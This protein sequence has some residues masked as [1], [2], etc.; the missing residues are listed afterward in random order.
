MEKFLN[1]FQNDEYTREAVKG[2]FFAQLDK[3]AIEAVYERKDTK[4]IADAKDVLE[5]AFTEL[6]E[7]YGKKREVEVKSIR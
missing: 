3:F 2:F 5:K 4:S 1:T 7:L 6:N